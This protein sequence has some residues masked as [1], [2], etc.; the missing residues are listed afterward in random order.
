[1]ALGSTSCLSYSVWFWRVKIVIAT[2]VWFSG[3]LGMSHE[4]KDWLDKHSFV[5]DVTEPMWQTPAAAGA[6]S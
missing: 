2:D 6:S 3:Q 1:M 4:D 5:L